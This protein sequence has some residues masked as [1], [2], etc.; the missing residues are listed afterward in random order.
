MAVQYT[1]DLLRDQIVLYG[2]EIGDFTYG[3]PTI[4][5]W[6][7]G[8]K[9]IIGRYCSIAG[10]V[11]ILLGGNH[12]PDWV[13]T[14]PF[15][16]IL[17]TWPEAAGITGHPQ[18]NGDV[19]IGSDVWLGIHSTILSGVTI[20]DGAVVAAHALVTKDVPPYAI[21]GGNPAA[22]IKY[23]FSPDIIEALL[24]SCWWNWRED[25]IKRTLPKLA[26]NDIDA[27][28]S[29]AREMVRE[30]YT[31]RVAEAVKQVETTRE[32]ASYAENALAVMKAEEVELSIL[33]I[34][35]PEII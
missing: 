33:E 15:S 31:A 17:D 16:G 3:Q 10:G 4:L 5:T 2:H 24:K 23:R 1:K 21:V 32:A 27:F 25:Q 28:L 34:Q 8:R 11:T 30:N 9:L 13:T 22:L 14:Y 12:R 29:I 7:E 19:R 26:S 20:G 6:G 35:N 18:S